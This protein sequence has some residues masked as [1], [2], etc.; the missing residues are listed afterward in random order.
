MAGAPGRAVALKLAQPLG[1][2]LGVI[3]RMRCSQQPGAVVVPPGAGL[4]AA[5]PPGPA[6]V[7][8]E[9]GAGDQPGGVLPGQTFDAGGLGDG[10]L[11]R[12]DARRAGLPAAGG[13]G[14]I[15]EWDAQV[16]AA[17]VVRA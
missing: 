10:E 6:Q 16:R 11:D 9:A 12:A 14:R 3:S 7:E 13:D 15:A 5:P 4:V 8:G 2:H 17:K 1:Q